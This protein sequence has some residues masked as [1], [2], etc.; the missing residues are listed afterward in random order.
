MWRKPP[1]VHLLW[2]LVL[3]KLVA[4]PVMQ[5]EG[6]VFPTLEPTAM[7]N[8]TIDE[9][10]LA[11]ESQVESGRQIDDQPTT[12]TVLAGS[13]KPARVRSNDIDTQSLWTHLRPIVP[14]LWVGGAALAGL[15]CAIRITRFE[16]AATRN[17]ACA[18]ASAASGPGS[19]RPARRPARAPDI[20]LSETV[21]VPL[22]WYAL[23]RP[24]IVL[25]L[26]LVQEFD[27]EQITMILAHEIAH[28]RRR[29]HWV[30]VVE[31]F[32]STLHWWNPLV[33]AIRRKLHDTE[34]LCCDSWVCWMFPKSAQRYAEVLLQVAES[35]G[36]PQIGSRHRLPACRFLS[37]FSLKERIEMILQNRFEPRVSRSS[38]L[39]IALATCLVIPMF[40]GRTKPAAFAAPNQET[41][42]QAA[43]TD[44]S[45]KSDFPFTVKFEQ[46]RDRLPRWRQDYDRR[47][48]RHRRHFCAG[49][50]LLDQGNV[51]AG[52][53]R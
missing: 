14:A 12:R 53:A 25:P 52:V 42:S 13:T 44:A 1:V 51:H 37:S 34:D 40:F 10:S 48:P 30:R 2:V 36:R 49:Q 32:V 15:L 41:S 3:L 11:Q 28:L 8:A 16:T 21:D 26:R 19:R 27:D 47:S 31:L 20:R 5:F 50:Y 9:R 7:R 24:R 35:A 29:D 22:V 23:G 33:W 6:P 43:R 17:A 18:P 45:A 39:A 38:L 4:P 46:A